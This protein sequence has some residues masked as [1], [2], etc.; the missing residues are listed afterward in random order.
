MYSVYERSAYWTGD[1]FTTWLFG[2]EAN[3]WEITVKIFN[4]YNYDHFCTCKTNKHQK[5][6]SLLMDTFAFD[7]S[8]SSSYYYHISSPLVLIEFY[9]SSNDVVTSDW[10][11]DLLCWDHLSF[12]A[13]DDCFIPDMTEL[14]WSWLLSRT[15]GI[16]CTISCLRPRDRL[17]NAGPYFLISGEPH[18]GR[19]HP[20]CYL[21]LS[22]GLA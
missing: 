22:G 8:L 9:R 5:H 20:Q 18:T 3:W 14:C 12:L 11:S 1:I 6:N 13:V 15:S 10:K 4:D 19:E 16:I 17:L 2:C 7:W 21:V